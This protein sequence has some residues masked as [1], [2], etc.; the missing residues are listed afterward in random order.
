SIVPETFGQ[1]EPFILGTRKLLGLNSNGMIASA[2]EL[3]LYD[4]HEG[5]LEV[6]D[7]IKPGTSF[8]KFY[9]LDDFILDIENKS[10]THRP[11]CFSTIGF[12]REVAAIS[13]KQFHTPDWLTDLSPDFNKIES[14]DVDL[15]VMIDNTELSSRYS[16]IVMSGAD[17]NKK[18]PTQ[19]QT[20]LSRIGMRPINAVVDVTNYLM[21]LTGQPLHAFDYDKLVKV[22]GGKAEIHVRLGRD[23]EKLELLD[24]RTVELTSD[25]I[26]IAAGEVAIALAGA[27]GGANTEIDE[28][29]KNIIIESATFNL[30]NLRAT[31]MR[32]GIFSE[33]ITRFTKGQ[34]GD[35]TAPVLFE[36]V[37]LM[38]EWAGAHTV[39][40]VADTY[41][42]KTD[43]PTIKV[44]QIFIN[45][46]LGS[47]YDIGQITDTLLHAE[48]GV[49]TEAQ[50]TVLVKPPYWRAD[51]HI[52]EDIIEE[53]GRINGFDNIPQALPIRNFT[54]VKPNDFDAFRSHIRKVLVRAGANEVL[55]YSFVHG[56]VLKKANQNVNNSYQLTNSISPDLQY[57]RQTLTPSLLDLVHPNIKQG[58]DNFAL[59]EINKAHSK[60]NGLNN[61]NV[62]FESE[63]VSLVLASKATSGAAAYYQ[64][65]RI[66][67]YLCAEL[68]VQ[69]SY[70][71]IEKDADEP[72]A[73]P[74]EYRRSAK[75]IDKSS[76]H[77]IG[78][79]GE[80]KKS[81]SKGF[82]LPVYAAGFEI[83]SMLL[84][85]MFKK[86]EPHYKPLSRYPSSERDVC[87]RV[88]VNV[89]YDQIFDS[90]LV[91]LQTDKYDAEI[92]PVD[93]Y[94]PDDGKTKNITI[95]I[96]LTAYDHTLT[97][98]EVNGFVN[99]ISNSVLEK[100]HATII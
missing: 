72:I 36:A 12:A 27:M 83:D 23:K 99:L 32:H 6:E 76:G 37:R 78:V 3:N 31:Q 24:G 84:F 14:H 8:A 100:T 35:Q 89:T 93:I 30:Y 90:A 42:G 4:E 58:F 92:S 62:P 75:I 52:P 69:L 40:A 82:K 16:A 68:G 60:A 47:N 11:D 66:F 49:D 41:P 64:A 54:A 63:M 61:E 1:K 21:M 51:V 91:G 65:K 73:K 2:R 80:Y 77:G 74:F 56:N 9:E 86:L 15:T 39:S 71:S 79:I 67:D 45:D 33:A 53:I 57:Y 7:D 95:R 10:L 48:F 38:R 28:N 20:Y 87:F 22:A 70:E 59:F 29:T 98:D 44:S 97:S 88:D 19:I 34:P 96:K 5:I 26:V 55:S 43:R 18:S 17:G 46:V 85:Y 50:Y 94:M 13:E 81:V 25:D